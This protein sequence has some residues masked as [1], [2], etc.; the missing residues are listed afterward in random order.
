MPG[1]RVGFC[2]GNPDLVNALA[3][4]KG[5]MDYG[6]F[7]PAQ[8]AAA[9]ALSSCDDDV[10]GNRALYKH[11]AEVLVGGLREAGWPVE[12]P[13]ATMFL[14]APL[15]KA[16]EAKGSVA[17]AAELLEQAGIAVAPGV[18]FGP[19]G[20]GYVRFSLIEPDDRVRQACAK[21]GQFLSASS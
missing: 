6:S 18:G 5:Y 16:H 8:L 3:T 14:W 1:W 17:F 4:I 20:E 21:V 9:T 19:G 12:P 11:R 15:P 13:Q 2:V 7:A 10:V